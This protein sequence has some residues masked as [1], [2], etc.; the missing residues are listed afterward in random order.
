MAVAPQL[1]T[2]GTATRASSRQV[3]AL[4]SGGKS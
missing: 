1:A 2:T 4:I 3:V